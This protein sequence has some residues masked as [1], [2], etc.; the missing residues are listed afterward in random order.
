MA[1]PVCGTSVLGVRSLGNQSEKI[2]ELA[3]HTLRRLAFT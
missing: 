1:G 2:A 3:P